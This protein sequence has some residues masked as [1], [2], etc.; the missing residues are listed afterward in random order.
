MLS[1]VLLQLSEDGSQRLSSVRVRPP[2][3]QHPP[4]HTRAPVLAAAALF[5]HRHL[6]APALAHNAAAQP[7]A[8]VHTAALAG[9]PAD[10]GALLYSVSIRHPSLPTRALA[11]KGPTDGARLNCNARAPA[12]PDR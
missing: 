4:L 7:L 6:F 5:V 8:A 10:A 9:L 1:S 3:L 2:V 12:A 11:K